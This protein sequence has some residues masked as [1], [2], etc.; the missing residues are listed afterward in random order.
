M[1]LASSCPSPAAQ[2]QYQPLVYRWNVV[3]RMLLVVFG[4]DRPRPTA[5]LPPSSDGKPEAATAV[6]ELLMMGMR[7]PETC[8]AVFKRQAINLRNYCVWL[9][10]SFECMMMHGLKTLN[11]L[12]LCGQWPWNCGVTLNN[13]A[14]KYIGRYTPSLT[15]THWLLSLMY[16]SNK[17]NLLL[18]V[19]STVRGNQSIDMPDRS[20]LLVKRSTLPFKLI[21]RHELIQQKV[22][23]TS[24]RPKAFYQWTALY[25][26]VY[27]KSWHLYE[28]PSTRFVDWEAMIWQPGW[29]S[30]KGRLQPGRTPSRLR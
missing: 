16:V 22:S 28:T 10:D 3:I 29:L 9:V 11:L 14:E 18:A 26:A 12:L 20:H 27:K 1:F 19:T 2:L 23:G 25:R 21:K 8:W 5:L 13:A 24:S 30:D 4:P 6:I 7:M 17:P 15:T